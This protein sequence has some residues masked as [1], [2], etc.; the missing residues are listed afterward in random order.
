ML[1]VVAHSKHK[2]TFLHLPAGCTFYLP[3]AIQLVRNR[4]GRGSTEQCTML[5]N[6]FVH[7][8][9]RAEDI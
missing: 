1:S 5:Q 9:G 7:Q 4:I 2:D 6:L 3:R 8:R